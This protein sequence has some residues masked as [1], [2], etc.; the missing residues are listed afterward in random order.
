MA[1]IEVETKLTGAVR[2]FTRFESAG[3]I[4]FL[5]SSVM[6]LIVANSPFAHLHDLLLDTTVAVQIS[7]S[8]IS[9]LLLL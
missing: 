9:N 4:L 6:A 7:T 8:V 3:G 2:E 1:E 5:V